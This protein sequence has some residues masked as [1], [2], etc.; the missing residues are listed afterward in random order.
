MVSSTNNAKSEFPQDKRFILHLILKPQNAKPFFV[1]LHQN[2]KS[3]LHRWLVL[4][5]NPPFLLQI[6]S[7][8]SRRISSLGLENLPKYIDEEGIRICACG[9]LTTFMGECSQS[10]VLS[11]VNGSQFLSS[12]VMDTMKGR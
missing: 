10:L 4:R 2:L 12:T 5:K 11:H 1:I 3:H 8:P 6:I 9:Q 7:S